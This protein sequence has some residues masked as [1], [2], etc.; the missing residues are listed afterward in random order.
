MNLVNE[1]LYDLTVDVMSPFSKEAIL[2]IGFGTGKFFNK[3]LTKKEEGL[4]VSGIDYSDEMVEIARQHN[5]DAISSGQL[6]IKFGRSDAIP[7]PDQSFD[8]VF[9]N[10]VIYFWDIPENHLKEIH[11]VLK[12]GGTFYTGI[13]T[14]KSM[15]FFPFVEFGFNLYETEEWKKILEQNGFLFVDMHTQSDPE[16]ELQGNPLNLESCCLVARKA[17]PKKGVS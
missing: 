11:R 17:N 12:P 3:I 7:F 13:R 15:L 1:P 14:K 6:T 4:K 8:K 2:E 5:H 16:I 10:M 9:C